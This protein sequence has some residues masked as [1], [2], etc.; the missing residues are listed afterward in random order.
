MKHN[1]AELHQVTY[2][3]RHLREKSDDLFSTRI[4][5]TRRHLEPTHSL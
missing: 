1:T 2:L 3:D 4:L 5:S